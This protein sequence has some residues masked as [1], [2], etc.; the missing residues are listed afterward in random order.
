LDELKVD[1]EYAE[2]RL[3]FKAP[4]VLVMTLTEE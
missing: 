3:G 1:D 4:N 2:Q